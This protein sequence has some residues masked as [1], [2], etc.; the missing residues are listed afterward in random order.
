GSPR[1][2]AV[3]DDAIAVALADKIEIVRG[4]DKRTIAIAGASALAFDG[5]KLGVG[6]EDGSLVVIDEADARTTEA[7]LGATVRRVCRHPR[8][9]WLATA[10]E[11]VHRVDDIGEVEVVTRATGK[12]PRAIA[13]SGDGRMIGIVLDAKTAVVIAYPSRDT[14]LSVIYPERGAR[15]ID[16]VEG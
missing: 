3:G 11:K 9:F 2:L 1:A 10:G 12:S 5:A 14:I 13:C 8:G 16:F 4:D 6:T 15:K 7:S